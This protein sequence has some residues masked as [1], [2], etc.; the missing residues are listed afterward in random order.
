MIMGGTLGGKTP[1]LLPED[2]MC[3]CDEGGVFGGSVCG[4]PRGRAAASRTASRV[5]NY[6]VGRVSL[7][8][9]PGR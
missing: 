9:R 3:V 6:G 1:S 8:G 2:R 7:S 5:S 4:V